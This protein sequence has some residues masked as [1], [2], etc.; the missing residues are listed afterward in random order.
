MWVLGTARP[1][2]LLAGHPKLQAGTWHLAPGTWHLAEQ[3][4]HFMLLETYSTCQTTFC[5]IHAR[6]TRTHTRTHAP[7]YSTAL[8]YPTLCTACCTPIEGFDRTAEAAQLRFLTA[9]LPGSATASFIAS[10]SPNHG[11]LHMS[12]SCHNLTCLR[13]IGLLP[14]RPDRRVPHYSACVLTG[15]H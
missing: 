5:Y 12:A 14:T 6:H 1:L 8:Y 13:R 7:Y 3:L 4:R 2:T 10:R 9:S 11:M 15:I